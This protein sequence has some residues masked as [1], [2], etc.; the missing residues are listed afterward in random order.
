[1][2]AIFAAFLAAAQAPAAPAACAAPEHRQFDFWI[3]SW[4][5]Y[6]TAGGP[7]VAHS[8]IERRY[9]G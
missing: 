1:M 6:P 2:L 5:V 3:G 4:D 7:L 9:G 8:L